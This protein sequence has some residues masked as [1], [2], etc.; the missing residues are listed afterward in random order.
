MSSDPKLSEWNLL[1]GQFQALVREDSNCIEDIFDIQFRLR[2]RKL[3]AQAV[4]ADWR[5]GDTSSPAAIRPRYN[6]SIVN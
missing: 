3:I 5:R 6:Y 2:F 4:E 1:L